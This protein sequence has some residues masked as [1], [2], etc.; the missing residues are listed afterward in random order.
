MYV[1]FERRCFTYMEEYICFE[2]KYHMCM[3]YRLYITNVSYLKEFMC[4][5]IKYSMSVPVYP[6]CVLHACSTQQ[7]PNTVYPRRY[8]RALP[9]PL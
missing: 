4:R 8:L 1:Y 9:Q 6:W 7:L 3:K 5:N 2:Y